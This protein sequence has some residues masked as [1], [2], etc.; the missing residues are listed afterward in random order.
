MEVQLAVKGGRSAGSSTPPHRHGDAKAVPSYLRPS[1][2]SCH[3]VCKYG[4]THTFEE[5]DEPKARVK[6][7]K[8]PSVSDNQKMAVIKVRSVSRRRVGDFSRAEKA[9]KAAIDK[10]EELERVE[11]K[12]ILSYD[13]LPD[14]MTA[15]V[16]GSG[17]VRKN[18]LMMEK[19]S[20][21]NAKITEHV[22]SF[23]GQNESPEKK[24]VKSVRSKLT[25]KVLTQSQADQPHN[26]TTDTKSLKPPKGKKLTSL[27]VEKKA[28]DQEMVHGY[29]TI[30]P[31]LIQSRANLLRDLE[32]E[33]VHEAT[34]VKGERTYSLDQEEFAA[35]AESSRP[36]PVHRRVK[37]MSISSRSVRIPFVR[38]AS[39]NSAASKLRSKSTKA[40]ILP[41]EEEKPSKIR[42][43]RGS[44]AGEDSSSTGR[45]IQLRIRSLRRR[46]VGGSGGASTGFIVP[47]M[48]LRH[49]KTLEKKKSQRLYNNL[50]EETASK[51]VKTK[52]SKVKALVGAFE[53][54]ISKIRK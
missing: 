6:P 23:K 42:F 5:K 24:L 19:K 41:S 25:R 46:G 27:L 4:G 53:T 26:T 51:L 35:A 3:H 12:D 45:G 40:Q 49:Q 29:Q 54:V 7:R 9:A 32:K 47:A 22:D 39:R 28:I 17:D 16:M 14:S 48:T 30:S 10:E 52:K 11:W 43:R 21:G 37:S 18:D 33:M 34:N 13:T 31:S 20:Y 50:I 36:I 8:Q 15:K 1:A 38:Q 2:G 44:V